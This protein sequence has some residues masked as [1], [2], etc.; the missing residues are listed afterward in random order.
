MV[1]NLRWMRWA[2]YA[3]RMGQM[4]SSYKI[5]FGKSEVKGL[6]ATPRVASLF[7]AFI[8]PES[9]YIFVPLGRIKDRFI[10]VFYCTFRTG[11]LKIILCG[12]HHSNNVKFINTCIVFNTAGLLCSVY[13]QTH[14]FTKKHFIICIV[15]S[16]IMK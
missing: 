12:C 16:F 14:S 7:Q 15:I 11:G 9:S 13:N 8:H 2:E 4:R 3:A 10:E 6:L 5:L 1:I